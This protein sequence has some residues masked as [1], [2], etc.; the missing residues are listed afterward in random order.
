MRAMALLLCTLFSAMVPGYPVKRVVFGGNFNNGDGCI[1]AKALADGIQSNV[2]IQRGEQASL[3]KVK[4]IV[5]QPV[6]DVL[7]FLA[8]KQQL[9][10]FVNTGIAVRTNNQLI[11][12]T[13]NSATAGLAVVGTPTHR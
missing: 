12:P 2:D 5:S 4:N 10:D 8:A 3:A 7:S 1:A 9:L 13:G 6:V 11:A